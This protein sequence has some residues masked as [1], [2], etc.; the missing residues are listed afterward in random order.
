MAHLIIWKIENEYAILNTTT[1]NNDWLF[2]KSLIDIKESLLRVLWDNFSKY[3]SFDIPDN[4]G[5][6]WKKLIPLNEK[7]KE[8]LLSVR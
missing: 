2:A 7:E 1:K 5:K 8:I 4:M 6:D 3:I